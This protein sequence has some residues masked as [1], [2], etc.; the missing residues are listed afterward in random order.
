MRNFQGRVAVVTGAASGIGFAL[1]RRFAAEGMKL[2]MADVERAVLESALQELHAGGAEAI[3]VPCDVSD[4]SQLQQLA[5]A[6]MDA[7]GAVH[8]LCNNAGVETGAPFA[9]IPV[10]SW[11]WV[12]GVNFGGVL[13]GCRI[14]LPLL[15]RS[16]EGHIVNTGSVAALLGNAAT[17]AP[18]VAS[19]AAI[20]GLS[21]VLHHEL[22]E[23]GE[24]IGVSILMPGAV[25]TNMPDSERNRPAGVPAMDDHP[26]RR[27]VM[28]MLREIGS[29]G[30][31]PDEVANL[32]LD[33]IREGRLYV[34]T[35]PDLTAELMSKKADQLGVGTRV[36]DVR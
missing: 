8:V 2:V 7:Y 11:E 18:Y 14:F 27:P 30:M 33:A 21:E 31:S 26:A 6:T 23:A 9:E 12:M 22:A 20:V 32:V 3:A 25:N 1:C 36:Q 13:H 34:V 28:E 5:D 15:R 24:P 29:A 19:K 35:H 16:E 17:V 10:P 4:L